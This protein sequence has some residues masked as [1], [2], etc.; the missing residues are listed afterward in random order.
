MTNIGKLSG[1]VEG[2]NAIAF[3][4]DLVA[5]QPKGEN[6]VQAIIFDRLA[7]AGCEVPLVD[8]GPRSVPVIGELIV[9]GTRN[10]GAQRAIL[11]DDFFHKLLH[12]G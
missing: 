1:Y 8:Y 10:V 11:Y 5:A 6:A 3:L 4:S 9:E 2:D 12:I 7:C